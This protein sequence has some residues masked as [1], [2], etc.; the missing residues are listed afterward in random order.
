[1]QPLDRTGPYGSTWTP[2][3]FK[4]ANGKRAF[5]VSAANGA[6]GFRLQQAL[7]NAACSFAQ[8]GQLDEGIESLG[9][10]YAAGHAL[11]ERLRAGGAVEK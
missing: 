3:S 2:P 10:A 5:N 11:G 9:K 4:S 8:G 6:E 1:V 7:Y